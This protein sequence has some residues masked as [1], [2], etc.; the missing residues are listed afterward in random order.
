MIDL[1]TV[2]N[3]L[4][5]MNAYFFHRNSLIKTESGIEFSNLSKMLKLLLGPKKN[6]FFSLT[7]PYAPPFVKVLE[8]KV[9][10]SLGMFFLF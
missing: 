5:N 7:R 10:E 4:R 1:L 3:D 8:N 2:S 6:R 9:W